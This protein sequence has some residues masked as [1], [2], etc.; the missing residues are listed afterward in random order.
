MP[1]WDYVTNAELTQIE[2]VYIDQVNLDDPIFQ[3]FPIQ[4]SDYWNIIW[5]QEDFATGVMQFRGLNGAP[6]HVAPLGMSE[7]QMSP[8]VYGEFQTIDESQMKRRA[9]NRSFNER[10]AINDLIMR[11]KDQIRTRRFNR[12]RK[13]LWD[14]V[15]QGYFITL[16]PTGAIA[17]A[18][19]WNQKVVTSGGG[20]PYSTL[21]TAT[22]F[23]D[24][25]SLPIYARGYSVNFGSGA[26]AYG[27][28]KTVNNIVN[29]QNPADLGGKKIA[30][31]S[32]INSLKDINT[33]FENQGLAT[34]KVWEGGYYDDT[35]T[36]QTNI[37]DS[38]LIVFGKR[39]D[40]AKLGSFEITTGSDGGSSLVSKVI[41]RM[42]PSDSPPDRIEIHEGFDGGPTLK[43]P[44]G[45]LRIAC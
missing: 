8:G 35:K 21:A 38:T 2:K 26:V 25:L 13:I 37:P 27:N 18:D 14:L 10:V 17:H 42:G 31:G 12:M 20:I 6:Q 39:T 19:S 34:V 11:V 33:V 16:G 28:I 7:F 9:M 36:W 1:T 41:S 3:M 5:R 30:G 15:C 24:L 29:N 43:Y 40:G 44:N 4:N 22:P 45:I 23:A 32:T